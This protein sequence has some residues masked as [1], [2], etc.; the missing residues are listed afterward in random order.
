MVKNKHAYYAS[1]VLEQRTPTIHGFSTRAFADMRKVENQGKFLHELGLNSSVFLVK[2]VHGDTVVVPTDEQV[3]ADAIVCSKL[4]ARPIG[5]LVADCVP[6]LLADTK[7]KAIAAVHAG[8]KGTLKNIVSKTV[9][10]MCDLGT[11]RKDIIASVGPRIGPCCYHVDGERAKLFTSVF[12]EDVR[13]CY[14]S[15]GQ[16]F[17]DLGYAN[18]RLLESAGVSR[19]RI[20][21]RPMCTSCQVD[22][23]YSYRR[24]TKKMFGEIISVIGFN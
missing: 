13:M 22:T 23:F 5:V 11:D 21:I 12:G 24:D 18:V 19:D 9:A 7:G 3:Q 20:D 17:L 1:D 16:S 10:R 2:Q 8:W 4:Y 6:V 15:N 14:E